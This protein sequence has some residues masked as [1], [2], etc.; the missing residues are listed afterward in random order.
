MRA[1]K[2][3]VGFRERAVLGL[4]IFQLLFKVLHVFLFALSEG[5]LRRTVLG[6]SALEGRVLG[7]DRLD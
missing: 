5:P 4:E 2:V 7:Q 3:C 1:V 6:T